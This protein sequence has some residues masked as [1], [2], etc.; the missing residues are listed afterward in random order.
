MISEHIGAI[1]QSRVN[2]EETGL[3]SHVCATLCTCLW[4]EIYICMDKTTVQQVQRLACQVRVL[5]CVSTSVP[6]SAEGEG[7]RTALDA[8]S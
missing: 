8:E 4:A 5:H 6:P 3:Q 7:V 2:S 1:G